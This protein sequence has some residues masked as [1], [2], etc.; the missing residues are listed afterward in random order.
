MIFK[1]KV[2]KFVYEH[3]GYE[4]NM[5]VEGYS[6]A[7]AVKKFNAEIRGYYKLISFD[8]FTIGRG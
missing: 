3:C 6:A 5:L 7:Q 1:K 4:Y 2:Y 8:E